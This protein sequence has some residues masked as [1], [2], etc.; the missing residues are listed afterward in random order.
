VNSWIVSSIVFV[1]LLGG[2]YL[3]ARLRDR[4]P[5]RHL[6]EGTKDVVRVAMSLVATMAALVL[7]LLVASA[8]SSYDGRIG[9]FNQMSANLILLDTTLEEYGSQ[10]RETRSLLRGAA[11]LMLHRAWPQDESQVSTVVA[12]DTI[13]QGRALYSGIEE[14]M[15]QTDAQR[16]LQAQALEIAMTLGNKRWLLAAQQE[17]SSIPMPFM[18][19]LIFWLAVLFASFGLFAPR[20]ATVVVTISLCAFSISG[21]ILLILELARPF[22]GILRISSAPLRNAIALLGH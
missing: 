6:D 20:N 19:V 7:G 10:A 21:A 1:S 2:A 4:L 11:T 18:L 5:A 22:E 9:E 14:L 16:R 8:K 17:G 13:D 15:P 3:G 12:S